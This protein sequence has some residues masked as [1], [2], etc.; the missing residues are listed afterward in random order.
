MHRCADQRSAPTKP[1]VR[2]HQANS[3]HPPSQ[4][5]APTK[6]TVRIHQANSPHPP[7]QQSAPT[8]STGIQI[9]PRMAWIYCRLQRS[10]EGGVGPVAG[11]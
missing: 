10:V 3:P 1:T 4:Q 6:P 11:A 8:R 2:I 9:H 7:S 5:S